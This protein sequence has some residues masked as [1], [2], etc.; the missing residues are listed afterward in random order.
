[1]PR[2]RD[3]FFKRVNS[4]GVVIS[5]GRFWNLMSPEDKKP[6]RR[7]LC[8]LEEAEYKTLSS[9]KIKRRS[10]SEIFNYLKSIYDEKEIILKTELE[11]RKK[12]PLKKG[13]YFSELSQLFYA[14]L[15]KIRSDRW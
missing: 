11:S 7:D 10:E 1:M 12:R 14:S 15:W 13:L 6:I 4:K 9:G 8:T 2:D 3:Y 5:A